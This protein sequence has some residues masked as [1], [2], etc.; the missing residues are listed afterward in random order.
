MLLTQ[1]P[2]SRVVPDHFYDF[3]HKLFDQ[4]DDADAS[5]ICLSGAFSLNSYGSIN[6]AVSALDMCVLTPAVR[7]II[8]QPDCF[9][10]E[11]ISSGG[12]ERYKIRCHNDMHV[13]LYNHSK[14]PDNLGVINVHGQRIQLYPA[15]DIIRYK[16]AMLSDRSSGMTNG[17]LQ[18]HMNDIVSFLHN[19]AKNVRQTFQTTVP[20][21]VKSVNA[22]CSVKGFSTRYDATTCN[23]SRYEGLTFDIRMSSS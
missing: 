23:D 7:N 20:T 18:K 9:V 5:T 19:S 2:S 14:F 21:L 17:Q 3:L 8:L 1:C 6:R 15:I 22:Y 16:M 13:C 11:D 12:V 10:S 4:L